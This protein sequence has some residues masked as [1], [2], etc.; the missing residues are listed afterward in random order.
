MTP[1]KTLHKSTLNILRKSLPSAT[2]TLSPKSA[3]NYKWCAYVSGNIGSELSYTDIG[4]F[5]SSDGGNTWRQVTGRIG[6]REE[7]FR[8][9]SVNISFSYR[10]SGSLWLC[11]CKKY[12]S[13]CSVWSV[14]LTDGQGGKMEVLGKEYEELEFSHFFPF[15]HSVVSMEQPPDAKYCAS[16]WGY[17]QWNSFYR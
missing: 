1:I 17:N 14:F 3:S 7:A 5:I 6:N 8:A 4:V 9:S 12:W 2:L 15:F 11:G 16:F 13:T 10:F